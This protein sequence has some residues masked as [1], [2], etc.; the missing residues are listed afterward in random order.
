MDYEPQWIKTIRVRM[1]PHIAEQAREE[2]GTF[3]ADIQT[4]GLLDSRIS[5]TLYAVLFLKWNS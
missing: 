3:V 4:R 5:K 2:Y 1:F